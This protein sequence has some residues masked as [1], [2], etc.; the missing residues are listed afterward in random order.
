MN[1]AVSA[2]NITITDS[3]ASGTALVVA[4]TGSLAGTAGNTVKLIASNAAGGIALNGVS[5]LNA[6]TGTADLSAGTGGITQAAGSVITAGTLQSTGGST[7]TVNLAGTGNA[8]GNLGAFAV[9]GADF[10]LVDSSALSVN[11]A[12]SANNITITDSAASGTALVVATTGSLAGTAGNTVKLIASNAAGGIALN[13]VSTL[14]ASTGTADL[15]AGT[16]GIT[17]A[18]GSVITAGTLQS[19]GGSTGTVNLAG[20]GNAI[21]GLGAFAVTGADFTLVDNSALTVNGATSANNVTVTDSFAGAP[22]ITVATGGALGSTAGHT[23]KLTASNGAGGISLTGSGRAERD[24]HGH[25][26]PQCRHGRGE[27]GG[28]EHDHGGHADRARGWPAR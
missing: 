2:N 3:A 13:G 5:T 14:N 20:T 26:G 7:G 24:G 10:T 11:G 15:S 16:G 9:T 25:S 8:I 18:T 22:A 21:G 4:T 28:R 17:Q 12:V 1:G 27:P 23:V 19:T 6:S